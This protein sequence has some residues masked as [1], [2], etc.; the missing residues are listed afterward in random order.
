MALGNTCQKHVRRGIRTAAVALM[1]LFGFS[2]AW[3]QNFTPKDPPTNLQI[4]KGRQVKIAF[5]DFHSQRF[6]ED[7]CKDWLAYL[8]FELT[9]S[10]PYAGK[11]TITS[12][13]EVLDVVEKEL[14]GIPLDPLIV[15]RLTSLLGVDFLIFLDERLEGKD[16]VLNTR[17]YSGRSGA[18]VSDV[19]APL[20][21][22]HLRWTA[23]RLLQKIHRIAHGTS[24]TKIDDAYPEDILLQASLPRLARVLDFCAKKQCLQGLTDIEWIAE[25]NRD[26]YTRLQKR[27][28]LIGDLMS[29]AKSPLDMARIRVLEGASMEA[30]LKLESQYKEIHS[31]KEKPT[32]LKLIGKLSILLN[33]PEKATEVFKELKK[34][35][36][37]DPL[38]DLGL[39]WATQEL[40]GADKAVKKLEA[41]GKYF[42]E[43]LQYL[44]ILL[45]CYQNLKDIDNIWKTKAR[46]AAAVQNLG[47]HLKAAGL[48]M[49]LLD[50]DFRLEWLNQIDFSLLSK[51]ERTVLMKMLNQQ[52][53]VHGIEEIEVFYNLAKLELVSENYPKARQ[54]M[55]AGL[56]LDKAHRKL[57]HLAA[58]D[59]LERENDL[60][61]AIELL[62]NVPIRE[63]NPYLLALTMEKS[64]RYAEAL[65]IWTSVKW[66]ENWKLE[67]LLHRAENLVKLE[68]GDDAA[69]II[70]D[71]LEIY[72]G[73]EEL[74]FLSASIQ[75]EGE[76]AEKKRNSM[77]IGWQLSGKPYDWKDLSGHLFFP[78][79][80]QLVLPLPLVGWREK[81]KMASVGKVMILNGTPLP[82]REGFLQ[83]SRNFIRPY[84]HRD[85][86]RIHSEIKQVLSTRFD[87]V[88]N[89]SSEQEFR[90]LLQP[91]V[92]GHKNKY[93]VQDLVQLANAM[94]VDSLVIVVPEETPLLRQEKLKTKLSLYF[95]DGISNALYKTS[96]TQ[97]FPFFEIYRFNIVLLTIPGILIV[98]L[99][100]IIVRFSQKTRHWKDPILNAQHLMKQADYYKA[101]QILDK[102]GYADDSSEMMGHYYVKKQDYKS[103]L[104]AFYKAKDYDNALIAL[105]FCPST[106]EINNLAG[107]I[108]FRKKDF[109]NAETYFRKSK[110]LLGI[111]KI[112]EAMGESKKAARVRAQFHFESNN[113]VQAVEEYRAIKD[114]NRAGVVFFYYRDYEQAAQMFDQAGNQ[115]MLKKCQL[116]L[117]QRKKGE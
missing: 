57:V 67:A 39:A 52:N 22:R 24:L 10:P 110:N 111:S 6:S 1:L 33:R 108:Y 82:S 18:Y 98:L 53:L 85:K 20:T 75:K 73:R 11:Y 40:Q 117:G 36:K 84:I 13:H 97:T 99:I 93:G 23:N 79:Y 94:N 17:M 15:P 54:I 3:A 28:G 71:A 91:R 65:D 47:N 81:G 43:D 12:H 64:K 87:I 68:K 100:L 4:Q 80:I 55:D 41:I 35:D 60:Q 27:T 29:E 19:S 34:L 48:W 115:K 109:G 2:H 62:E 77:A 38:A 116:R 26:L 74:H 51:Q 92:Q 107:D 58:W 59:A 31:K 45:S 76:D 103:A 5:V 105:R 56:K 9:N 69:N 104:E 63:R 114:Y 102:H 83:K 112:F 50:H 66:A 7:L 30:S 70:R 72:S 14:K 96:T 86:S 46:I 61:R 113:P 37:K 25:N 49:E 90:K 88:E 42:S 21:M 101:A 78:D 16:W 44:E 32:Y 106:D 8:E 89:R 95:F